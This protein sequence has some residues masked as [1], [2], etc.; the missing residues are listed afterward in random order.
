MLSGEFAQ[1]GGRAYSNVD[2]PEFGASVSKHL[3]WYGALKTSATRIK[4]A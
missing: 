1:S 3:V 2:F 4:I